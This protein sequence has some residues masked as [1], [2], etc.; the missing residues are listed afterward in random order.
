MLRDLKAGRNVRLFVTD[1][2][3]GCA[4]LTIKRVE[5]RIRADH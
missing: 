2:F 1:H 5:E 4:P 3:E